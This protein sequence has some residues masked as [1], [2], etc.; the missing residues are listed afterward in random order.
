MVRLDQFNYLVGETILECQRIEH[1]IKLIYAGMLKGEL[2]E[3]IKLVEN[4]PLG[5]VLKDL[6]DLDYSDEHP[7]LSRGDYKLLNEI[8][9]IR[10]WLVHKAYMEFLYLR[11]QQLD[12]AY[13]NNYRKLLKFHDRM[14]SL[15]DNVEN[16]RVDIMKHFGRV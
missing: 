13:Q 11:D 4:K 2:D 15:G 16:V 3:N 6:E 7:Y 8:K 5:P 1:D 9:D 14:T 10:N 12:R